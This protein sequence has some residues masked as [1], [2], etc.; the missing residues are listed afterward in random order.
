M[1]E[2]GLP[3][4]DIKNR[5]LQYG[6]TLNDVDAVLVTHQHQDHAKASLK[7]ATE[8]KKKIYG[9]LYVEPRK[10]VLRPFKRANITSLVECF[11]FPVEHDAENSLGFVITSGKET[12]LFVND[13]KFFKTDLSD[14]QFDVVMM[15]CNYQAQIVHTLYEKAKKENNYQMI[16]RYERLLNAHMSER[17]CLKTLKKLNLSKC[18]RIFLMHLS[19]GHSN[20]HAFKQLFEKELGV[21]T[22]ICRKNGGII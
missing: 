3:M 7:M 12:L 19:D 11:P 17:N 20:E 9:N 18:K 10:N 22:S 4:N 2:V 15:E 6:K 1:I 21:P 13:C 16:K 5:L 8:G 14:I